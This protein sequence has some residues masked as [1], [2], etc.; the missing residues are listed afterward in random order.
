MNAGSRLKQVRQDLGLTQKDFAEKLGFK[1]YKIKDMESGK[2][3]ITY[4]IAKLIEKI[5]SINHDWLLTG[6]GEIYVNKTPKN[7]NQGVVIGGVG[8][9]HNYNITTPIEKLPPDVQV[10]IEELL[11]MDRDKRKKV[12][13]CILEME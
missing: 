6:E 8:D 7:I 3:N 12:L 9:N 13:K 10:I 1:W 4:D 2:Q 11:A 5:F